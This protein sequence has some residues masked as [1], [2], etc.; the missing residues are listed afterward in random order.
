MNS[1][2]KKGQRIARVVSEQI[3]KVTSPGLVRWGP[4]FVMVSEQMDAFI[5]SLYQWEHSG[6]S[7]DLETV[8]QD[9]EALL[10]AWLEADRLYQ[11]S[12]LTGVPEVV[13]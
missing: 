8:Q 4:S 6:L 13:A 7:E 11:E 3:A 9:S 5:D 12:L 2:S 10:A 1:R